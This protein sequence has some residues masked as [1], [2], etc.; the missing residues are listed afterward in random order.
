M[1]N[2]RFAITFFSIFLSFLIVG[3][4]LHIPIFSQNY[5]SLR[6]LWFPDMITYMWL[7][8]MISAIFSLLCIYS[9]KLITKVENKSIPF[10]TR[11]RIN[12]YSGK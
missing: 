9:I 8:Y 12:Y 10:I 3:Y 5:K 7:I 6:D 1:N 4:L 11:C 2:K